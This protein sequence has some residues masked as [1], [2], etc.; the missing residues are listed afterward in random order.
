MANKPNAHACRMCSNEKNRRPGR[1]RTVLLAVCLMLA[2][3][4]L[5]GLAA[6]ENILPVLQ[7]PKPEVIVAPAFHAVEGVP[8][9]EAEAKEGGI[10]YAYDGVGY[11]EYLDFGRVLAQDGYELTDSSEGA[12]GQV[13]ATL[14]KGHAALVVQFNQDEKTLRVTYGPWARPGETAAAPDPAQASALPELSQAISFDAVTA[15]IPGRVSW[16]GTQYCH[17]YS[18][19]SYAA[20]ERFG[21][22]LGGEGY[23]LVSAETLPDGTARAKV[24]KDGIMLTLDYYMEGETA[25]VFYPKGI[26][27][28]ETDLYSDFT[29]LFEDEPVS[30]ADGVTL[31]LLG[32]QKADA[33]K[34]RTNGIERTHAAK[35]GQMALL[36]LAIRM[37]DG[38]T[39]VPST[40]LK[41]L[42]MR[43]EKKEIAADKGIENSETTIWADAMD[44]PLDSNKRKEFVFLTAAELTKEQLQHP[45]EVAFTFSGADN[46]VRYVAY[47]KSP[48]DEAT[49][50]LDRERVQW[51]VALTG[52]IL[53]GASDALEGLET[54]VPADTYERFV[55]MDF[56]HPDKAIV[57]SLTP[58]QAD[59]A[60]SALANVSREGI[61]PALAAYLNQDYPAYAKAAEQT[62]AQQTF[63]SWQEYS[64]LVL[65]PCGPH[66]AAVS[67]WGKVAEAALIIS[68]EE[69]SASLSTKDIRTYAAQLGLSGL[70]SRVYEG[71]ELDAL[72]DRSSFGSDQATHI[73]SCFGASRERLL[74]L[75]RHFWAGNGPIGGMAL[76]TIRAFLNRGEASLADARFAATDLLP[77]L[78]GGRVK[79]AEDFLGVVGTTVTDKAAAPDFS[80]SLE[81]AEQKQDPDPDGTYVFIGSSAVPGREAKAWLNL[82]LEAAL[83]EKNIPESPEAADYVICMATEYDRTD[84][85]LTT[86]TSGNGITLH[87]PLTHITVHD[88]GTGTMLKDLGWTVRSLFGI[89]MLPRGDT[90]WD[91]YNSELWNKVKGL[92]GE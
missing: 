7:T 18:G 62:R 76:G 81:A 30:L 78:E 21:T 4:V 84:L 63:S 24:G 19:V 51:G 86:G 39:W 15:V 87:Y 47:L 83:P 66:I 6:A 61:A 55:S 13:T 42:T 33:Y 29:E 74:R 32:W 52:D 1:S 14:S 72:L 92:F 77:H 17:E 22:K 3:I 23:T 60:A 80:L 58:E 67:F 57:I 10:A 89:V 73:Q 16:G 64:G 70:R 56:L 79:A 45:E 38:G 48:V 90:Y 71:E 9:P 36:R 28:R 65:L 43:F 11:S 34:L 82:Y 8:A 85:E 50:N 88:A 2:G 91:P 26:H 41:N 12:A 69:S 27:P 40:L 25:K 68:T 44:S 20:Y 5:Y 31:R 37:E 49:R 54:D 59:T 46:A 35:S 75:F 53:A